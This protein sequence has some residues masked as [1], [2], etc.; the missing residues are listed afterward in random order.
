MKLNEGSLVGGRESGLAVKGLLALKYVAC[1]VEEADRLIWGKVLLVFLTCHFVIILNGLYLGFFVRGQPIF[2]LM[3]CRWALLMIYICVLT[4]LFIAGTFVARCRRLVPT[5]A[6][7]SHSW[8][9][10]TAN[11]VQ[12]K[13]QIL[14]L[15]LM[16]RIT[17]PQRGIGFS[18]MQLTPTIT[19]MATVKMTLGLA[20]RFILV[21][22]KLGQ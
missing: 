2:N 5:L 12:V 1:S 22:K 7:L 14:I 11:Q 9:R 13:A 19:K 8:P 10:G 6:H 15:E 18:L 16:D 4:A 20:H 3:A 17:S 21:V